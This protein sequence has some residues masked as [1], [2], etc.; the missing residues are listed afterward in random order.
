MLFYKLSNRFV[1]LEENP[2][3]TTKILVNEKIHSQDFII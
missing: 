2:K 1:V 3:L